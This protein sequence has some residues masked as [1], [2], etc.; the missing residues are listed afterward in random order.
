[1]LRLVQRK[2]CR[3][4]SLV[5]LVILVSSQATV[6]AE[7]DRTPESQPLARQ[8]KQLGLSEP[9]QKYDLDISFPIDADEA[10]NNEGR[11]ERIDQLIQAI[12][13][14]EELAVNDTLPGTLL[15]PSSIIFDTTFKCESGQVVVDDQCVPCPPGTYFDEAK[16]ICTKCAIGFYNPDFAQR[17][18]TK[19][20]AVQDLE[21]VTKDLGSTKSSDCK[22]KCAAGHFYDEPTNLCRPCGFGNYQP[23]EGQ[24]RCELCGVGLTTRTKRAT[25]EAECREDCQDGFQLGLTGE[26][27][28]CPVGTYRMQ[29]RDRGCKACPADRTTNRAASKTI[30][31]CNLPICIPGQ[32]LNANDNECQACPVGTFQPNSQETSC[33]RCPYDTST[34]TVG[35]TNETEC[36]NPCKAKDN[37]EGRC[38]RN[39]RCLF[40]KET[41]D[42]KCECKFGYEGDGDKG[43][44]G[45]KS[46]CDGFCR[47][48]GSCLINKEGSPYCTCKGSFTGLNCAEKSDFAY[49][50]GGIAGAVLFVIV[51]VLLI[52][53]IFIRNARNRQRSSEKFAPSVGDMTGSQVN[54]YYGQPAPYAESIAPSHHGSTY[55]HY[56]EDEED[57]WGMPNFYDT[58]G[59]NSKIA[60]SNG[61]LYNA[62]MYAP[63]YAP[64]GELYDRLGKHAY[65][66]RPEDKSGNDTTSESD[67][68]RSRRQ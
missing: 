20:P 46:K 55:A 67:D 40:L 43:G 1:M 35:A 44:L 53:M 30:E 34:V 13:N 59:K 54:F 51:L 9:E 27:E 15:D 11:R 28:Q 3:L 62:G 50:A 52:W 64:Q 5:T 14:D 57:G 31:D 8:G 22:Q 18:C 2:V 60:R 7:G 10:V 49:I 25:S 48:G 42:H 24:F 65:Q 37:G 6:Q 4:V 63:Q 33:I 26:C 41:N 45:C 36:T 19:C 21:G 66:P 17:A 56:Y 29:G 61:S 58:Y 47:N 16:Q 39:A 38:D 32:Y 68:D 23:E 12:L